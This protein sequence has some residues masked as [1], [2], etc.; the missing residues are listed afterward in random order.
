MVTATS[1]IPTERSRGPSDK[2]VGHKV[3]VVINYDGFKLGPVV[4][5]E[6]CAAARRMQRPVLPWHHPL[7]DQRVHEGQAR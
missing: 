7:H 4:E 3:Y 5:D 6:F 1:I 2:I